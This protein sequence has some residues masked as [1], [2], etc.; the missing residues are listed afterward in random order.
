MA[1][2]LSSVS[3][4][5]TKL[6]HVML[7]YSMELFLIISYNTG[8][9]N[10]NNNY[11]LCSGHQSKFRKSLKSLCF[12]SV[13]AV[14]F[15]P[16]Q[17]KLKSFCF[18]IIGYNLTKCE[19]SLCLISFEVRSTVIWNKITFYIILLANSDKCDIFVG[20]SE[21]LGLVLSRKP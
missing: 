16:T 11:D 3:F 15:R 17:E 19:C 9:N 5:L 10:I 21:N 2:I 20:G 6:I 14:Y 12:F 8:R 4:P 7:S 18:G 13:S 1:S